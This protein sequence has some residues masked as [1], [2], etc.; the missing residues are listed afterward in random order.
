MPHTELDVAYLSF[1]RRVGPI[2]Q[3]LSR[4]LASA[5]LADPI[6]LDKFSGDVNKVRETHISLGCLRALS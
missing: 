3:V 6:Y 5:Q 4:D 1:L 2:W